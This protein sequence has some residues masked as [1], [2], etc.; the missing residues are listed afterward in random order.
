MFAMLRRSVSSLHLASLVAGAVV[1]AGNLAGDPY[2]DSITAAAQAR[3]TLQDPSVFSGLT[4]IDQSRLSTITVDDGAGGRKTIEAVK[5]TTLTSFTSPYDN[6]Q[7]L[8]RFVV[9]TAGHFRANIWVT[10]EGDITDYYLSRSLPVTDNA[11]VTFNMLQALGIS[12]SSKYDA[13][14]FYVEPKFV[15]RP[16]FDPSISSHLPPEW[17]GD[18]YTFSDLASLNP[19]YWGFAPTDKIGGKYQRP[20][21]SF[22]GPN[23]YSDWLNAWSLASYDLT[24]DRAFPY[25]G[26]GWTWNWNPDPALNGFALSEFIVSGGAEFYFDSLQAPIGLVPEPTSVLLLGVGLALFVIVGRRGRSSVSR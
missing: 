21:T 13:L 5:V 25:T 15:S 20:F 26:L 11:T 3:S 12:S 8:Q 7:P 18:H 23:S 19:S 16:S 6:A 24:G 10:V 2:S 1:F 14:T 9:D 17:T 22:E 4:L